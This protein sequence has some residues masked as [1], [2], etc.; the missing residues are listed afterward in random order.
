MAA[1]GDNEP[2]RIVLGSVQNEPNVEDFPRRFQPFLKHV[3]VE[4]WYEWQDEAVLMCT[5]SPDSAP[6][7]KYVEFSVQE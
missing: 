3:L 1:A 2:A 5:A 7:A 6:R 4:K